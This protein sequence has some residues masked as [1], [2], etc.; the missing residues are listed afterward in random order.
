MQEE[1]IDLKNCL[2]MGSGYGILT[3]PTN[4]FH[5][6]SEIC[7]AFATFSLS[8]FLQKCCK[9]PPPWC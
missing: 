9:I 5:V 8:T 3:L 7:M 4:G 1:G 6:F 2:C